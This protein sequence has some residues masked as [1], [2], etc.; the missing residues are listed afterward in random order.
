MDFILIEDKI[1]KDEYMYT[2]QFLDDIGI[3][4]QNHLK[5]GNNNPNAMKSAKKLLD[6]TREETLSIEHCPECFFNANTNPTKWFTIPCSKK[7]ALLWAKLNGYPYWPAKLMNFDGNSV[8]VRFFGDQHE[9]AHIPLG[10]CYW[11]AVKSPDKRIE[12]RFED[13]FQKAI[14][15]SLFL[16]TF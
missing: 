8:N 16:Y 2:Q 7:H 5:Q 15:V 13:G 4:Q 1:R 9:R 12:S 11:L 10:N 3:I 14:S 6:F